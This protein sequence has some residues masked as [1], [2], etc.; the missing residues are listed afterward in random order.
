MQ[1]DRIAQSPHVPQCPA[2]KADGRKT[3]APSPTRP[4]N[5]PIRAPRSSAAKSANIAQFPY[6]AEAAVITR[7]ATHWTPSARAIAKPGR[8]WSRRQAAPTSGKASAIRPLML[9]ARS[10]NAPFAQTE[11]AT[12]QYWPPHR[13]PRQSSGC[14]CLV[15]QKMT[16][17]GRAPKQTPAGQSRN[18]QSGRSGGRVR[19]RKGP[20]SKSTFTVGSAST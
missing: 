3:T 20:R 13:R 2:D 10:P 8:Q 9:P 6:V 5:R 18:T 12:E 11:P 1:A 16:A 14:A 17:A 15:G 7:P 19:R 4:A